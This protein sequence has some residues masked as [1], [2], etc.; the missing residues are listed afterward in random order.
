MYRESE[1][2]GKEE[3]FLK[4]GRVCLCVC[5]LAHRRLTNK[6]EAIK[7]GVGGGADG[8]CLDEGVDGGLGSEHGVDLGDV[9]LG[10][11]VG[12]EGWRDVLVVE[13]VPVDAGKEGVGLD[14]GKVHSE[15]FFGITIEKLFVARWEV[16]KL[17]RKLIRKKRKRGRRT[18]SR[19][20]W[21]AGEK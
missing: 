6:G 4:D 15:T 3:T 21:A 7:G 10:S 19:R 18:P 11:N 12:F 16:R 20:L 13:S 8:A 17:I 2:D 14:G 1:K 5:P 9:L